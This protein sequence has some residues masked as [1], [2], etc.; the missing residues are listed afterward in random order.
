MNNNEEEKKVVKVNTGKKVINTEKKDNKMNL[1]ENDHK[2]EKS[3]EEHMAQNK[4]NTKYSVDY[5]NLAIYA[6]MILIVCACGF[7]LFRF[8]EKYNNG[9]LTRTTVPTT[10]KTQTTTTTTTETIIFETTTSVQ[11]QATHTVFDKNR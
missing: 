1:P 8:F 4:K 3:M 10:I 7:L 11:T 9:E 5:Q 6:I 2:V